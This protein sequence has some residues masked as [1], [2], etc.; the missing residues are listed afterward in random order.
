M[1]R[2][3]PGSLHGAIIRAR[4]T[5]GKSAHES[6]RHPG[7]RVLGFNYD[8]GERHLSIEGFLPA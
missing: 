7:Q 6:H 4:R 3:R 1:H 8:T 5:K 2:R